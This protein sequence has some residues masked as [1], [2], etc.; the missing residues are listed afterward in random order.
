MEKSNLTIELL[1]EI[2]SRLD[3][4]N[5]E[6][7]IDIM[8]DLA[9]EYEWVAEILESY[10]LPREKM[11]D[12]IEDDLKEYGWKSLL[13]TLKDVINTDE[14]YYYLDMYNNISNININDAERIYDFIEEELVK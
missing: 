7:A 4:N 8:Y 6:G 12:F 11:Q 5:I 3:D 9:N 2:R 14:P 1:E 13:I 10:I